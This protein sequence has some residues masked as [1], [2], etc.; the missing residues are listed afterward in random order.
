MSLHFDLV[1]ADSFFSKS[2]VS[3]S[4]AEQLDVSRESNFS[5]QGI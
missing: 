4:E 3:N 5:E 2:Y 1:N